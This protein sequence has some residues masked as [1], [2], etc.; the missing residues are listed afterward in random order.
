MALFLQQFD[1]ANHSEHNLALYKLKQEKCEFLMTSVEYLRHQIS[2]D[3]IQ[4]IC[5]HSRITGKIHSQLS[6]YTLPTQCTST[7]R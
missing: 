6:Y 3:G 7:S 2:K 1:V 4:P 5:I